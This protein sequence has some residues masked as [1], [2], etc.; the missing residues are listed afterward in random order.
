VPSEQSEWGHPDVAILFTCLSFYYDG[1]N[2]AQ[3]RQCLEHMIKLDDPA[4]EYEK[5]VQSSPNFP[6]S[7]RAW[8][9]INTD[10]DQQIN[11]IWNSVRYNS[12]AID[13][14]LNNFVFPH[15]AKQFKVKLQSNGWDIPLSRP[16]E[17]SIGHTDGPKPLTTGFSG[18]NDNRTMLPLNIKQQDLQGLSHTSAEVLHYLLQPRNREC[19][20]STDI[21]FHQRQA[22][23]SERDLLRSLRVRNI[24][25]LIDAGAQIL[26]MNNFT[27]AQEWLKVDWDAGGALYFDRDRPM[28]LLRS[29]STMPLVASP[30]A[31]D[32][33]NCLVYLDDVRVFIPLVC[34]M[35]DNYIGSHPWH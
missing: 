17:D 13:Y 2:Q 22:K 14:F 16:G 20:L 6:P 3:L 1:I 9:S 32:L 15:H 11:D 5:W 27:L 26:E 34:K 19:I 12:T 4:T 10:D 23:A 31:E 28:V 35:S 21:M 18:T 33:N 29:G 8:N 30:Y 24:R 7:L 25:I